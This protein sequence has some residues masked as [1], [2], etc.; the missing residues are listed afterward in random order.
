VTSN[1]SASK[2]TL[3]PLYFVPEH[4]AGGGGVANTGWIVGRG[5]PIVVGAPGAYDTNRY[6]LYEADKDLLARNSGIGAGA[7]I[8]LEMK[9]FKLRMSLEAD[10]S[11]LNHKG[12]KQ[13]DHLF[14]NCSFGFL[15]RLGVRLGNYFTPYVLAGYE[16]N[17]LKE[18]GVNP[19][20]REP[21]RIEFTDLAVPPNHGFVD[22]ERLAYNLNG[23]R[24]IMSPRLGCGLE[25]AF[26]GR[27]KFRFDCFW[28]IREKICSKFR[29]ENTVPNLPL[30]NGLPTDYNLEKD[31]VLRCQKFSTRFGLIMDL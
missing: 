18:R 1:Y 23:K 30:T 2:A 21:G 16:F 15:Y 20:F 31:M 7:I 11:M 26:F 24:T 9:V 22:S 28:T 6:V 19:H 29:T 27:F 10:Y 5:A 12:N 14:E 8:G 25:I 17:T 4:P 13:R 3:E